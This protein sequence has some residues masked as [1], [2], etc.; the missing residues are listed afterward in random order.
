MPHRDDDVPR[1]LT[2]LVRDRLDRL[3]AE[4]GEV[5]RWGAAL[6]TFI[7]VQRLKEL[8]AMGLE[9]LIGALQTLERHGLLQAF[10]GK[11]GAQ[12][13][14][15]FAHDLVRRAV[16]A[17]LSEPRRRLMHLRVAQAIHQI[18]GDKESAA[19]EI[20]H[21][22]ALAGEASMAAQACVAA[23]RRCL[24][25]FAS[26]DAYGLA[27]RGMRYAAE[28]AE[29]ECTQL[30]LELSEIKLAARR[31]DQIEEAARDVELLAER[32]LD[33]GCLE[34][35]RLGFHLLSY[36]RW[37]VGDWSAAQAQT[38]RA[39][40]ISRSG[41]EAE[42]V[43][44]M[45]EA[46]RCLAMLERD[47]SHAEALLLEAS[48]LS[49]RLGIE[50]VAVPDAVGLLRMHQGRL[51][52][53]AQ[54]FGHARAL[55]R[56]D[57]DRMG[58]FQALEHLVMLELQRAAWAEAK[59]LSAEL[60]E[61]GEKLREG[62]EAAFAGALLALS[63]YALGQDGALGDLERAFA[64]LRIVDAKHRLA[65]ALTRAADL[66]LG[67]GDAARAKERASEGLQAARLLQRP[68]EVALALIVL[69]EAD[70]AMGNTED[71]RRHVQALQREPLPSV[72]AHVRDAARELLKRHGTG[73]AERRRIGRIAMEH[74][75]V[76]RSFE[77]P[78]TPE[79]VH[80]IEKGS[81]WCMQLHN[82]RRLH[83]YLS[84]D[85][86]RM[87]CLFEAPDAESVR[88]MSRQMGAP[89]DRIWTAAILEPPKQNE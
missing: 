36:L 47:L 43:V 87:V 82:V 60:V 58:E 40:L 23:G 12:G 22:A 72:S 66:H 52:E 6:G 64:A 2:D 55:S 71:V 30:M 83:S 84:P 68:S 85:G 35:A 59:A 77:Q 45:A 19:A 1:T 10:R 26:A 16:Y 74:V 49:A 86:L 25:L 31:P 46:A 20:A 33:Q 67:R 5:L 75:I 42:R 88:L 32:A 13:A 29:P 17:E 37:E 48:A 39:E 18:D 15:T 73:A 9:G 7:S 56:R 79:G 78:M 34:H 81:A 11:A 27:R 3:P 63:Q 57:G 80:E 62:S 44:A 61:I 28:L 50:P 8:T 51:G 14:Y 38:L 69:A 41:D 70:A 65:Y 4:A 21:H 53:A 89:V 54:L 24:R 76:E